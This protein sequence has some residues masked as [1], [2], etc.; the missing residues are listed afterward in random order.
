MVSRSQIDAAKPE[1]VLALIESWRATAFDL[2]T[3]SDDYIRMM[4]RPGGQA[5]SGKTADAAITASHAD[6]QE[7]VRGADAITGMADRAYLG[8]TEMVMPK[9]TNVR[10]MIDN[11]ECQG[12]VVSDDLLVSWTRPAGISDATAEKYREATGSFS[13]QIKDG[14][15]GWWVAEQQVSDQMNRDRKALGSITFAERPP[16]PKPKFQIVDRTWRQDPA[17]PEQPSMSREQAAA[18]LKDVNQRIWQHN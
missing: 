7:I 15:R 5:W 8:M 1:L 4:E 6:R 18:G 11:A 2:E 12:F 16:S 13:Q 14:A 9:L 17:P 3:C 10:A